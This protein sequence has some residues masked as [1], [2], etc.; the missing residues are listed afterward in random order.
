MSDSPVGRVTLVTGDGKGKTTSALGQ[1]VRALGH[2]WRVAVVQFVKSDDQ[3]GEH[4]FLRSLVEAGHTIELHV[5]GGGFIWNK[6]NAPKHTAKAKEGW[7]LACSL[8][9]S[10]D[11]DLVVLD[12][13]TYVIAYEMIPEQEILDG[14][15]NRAPHTSVVVTGRDASEG[16]LAAADLISEI[17]NIRHPMATGEKARQGLE[18]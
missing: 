13:L 1:V 6:A 16:L 4:R 18:F 14:I 10:G 5:T 8:L 3:C 2:G 11:Y 17:A 15:K 12:E 7:T 9:A